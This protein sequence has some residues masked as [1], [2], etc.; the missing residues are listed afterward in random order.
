MP[1]LLGTRL[2]GVVG[3][4]LYKLILHRHD[5]LLWVEGEPVAAANS[6]LDLPTP[7]ITLDRLLTFE[8]TLNMCQCTANRCYLAAPE[9]L[10]YDC[11]F[12]NRF[13]LAPCIIWS[14]NTIFLVYG[15]KTTYK[16]MRTR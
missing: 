10:F 11:L 1:R 12:G 15:T 8:T 9:P 2:D 6:V 7:N 16:A 3:H 13:I 4:P 14:P 5:Q